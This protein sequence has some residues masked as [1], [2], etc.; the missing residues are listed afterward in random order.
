M[1]LGFQQTASQEPQCAAHPL[2]FGCLWE[3]LMAS[4][5]ADCGRDCVTV[6]LG[7][8]NKML[9]WHFWDCRVLSLQQAAAGRLQA[10]QLPGPLLQSWH[11]IM[12]GELGTNPWCWVTSDKIP[13]AD[14]SK[15][16]IPQSLVLCCMLAW[17]GCWTAGETRGD[18]A[19]GGFPRSHATQ[20]SCTAAK[21]EG[22]CESSHIHLMCKVRSGEGWCSAEDSPSSHRISAH[23]GGWDSAEPWPP[24]CL[25]GL[26]FRDTCPWGSVFLCH[27][28]YIPHQVQ[29][30]SGFIYLF[31]HELLCFC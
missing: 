20:I 7:S 10:Q 28:L 12:K 3:Q 16:E 17:Q 15:A 1:E 21:G 2:W 29:L 11:D 18:A 8:D 22:R 4:G 13:V 14:S 6:S 9:S 30:S 23:Q 27:V 26:S 31:L 19:S 24:N 5:T 25:P